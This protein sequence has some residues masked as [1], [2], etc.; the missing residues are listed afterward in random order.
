MP[1]PAPAIFPTLTPPTGLLHRHPHPPSPRRPVCA[2]V[3]LREHVRVEDILQSRICARG[4]V[5]HKNYTIRYTMCSSTSPSAPALASSSAAARLVIRH[6]CIPVLRWAYS[7][8]LSLIRCLF[9]GAAS[10][11]RRQVTVRA[12]FL[13]NFKFEYR[14]CALSGATQLGRSTAWR[15]ISQ[16]LHWNPRI[17]ELARAYLRHAFGVAPSAPLPPMRAFIL[18]PLLMLYSPHRHPR[19]ARRFAGWCLTAR[20]VDE[21]FAPLSTYV[22]RVEE[23][24]EEL[25]CTRGIKVQRVV[26]TRDETSATW[27]EEVAAYRWHRVDHSTTVETH[28]RWHPVLIDVAIQS[29]GG[30]S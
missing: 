7:G 4:S 17:E 6:L 30:G 18:L 16:Y 13:H 21:C 10:S 3:N 26:L 9:C 20:P 25:Q 8:V 24:R 14:L 19:P 12:A 29:D 1:A 27:L 28:N 15:F 2:G 23:V 5:N 22:R 11:D